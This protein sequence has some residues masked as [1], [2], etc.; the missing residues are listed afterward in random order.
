MGKKK[1]IKKEVQATKEIPVV[2]KPEI[3]EPESIATKEEVKEYLDAQT[4]EFIADIAEN[5][6]KNPELAEQV[7]NTPE[8]KTEVTKEIKKEILFKSFT[9]KIEGKPEPMLL[10]L[11]VKVLKKTVLA[12][13]GGKR[14]LTTA[15]RKSRATIALTT[16]MMRRNWVETKEGIYTLNSVT[17]NTNTPDFSVK[18]TDSN[19]EYSLTLG[20]G[21]IIELDS[22]MK[23]R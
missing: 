12:N 1:A 2:G 14:T 3:V 15:G 22:F 11:A 23:L 20:K 21:A 6:L 4:S 10:S 7:R 17:V 13:T 8:R 5:L 9:P 19:K 18:V 16:A